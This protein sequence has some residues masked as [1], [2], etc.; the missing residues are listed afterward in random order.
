LAPSD[1]IDLRIRLGP[2]PV[3]RSKKEWIEGQRRDGLLDA[4]ARLRG[5][6]IS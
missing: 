3:V 6:F 4:V 1:N 5:D 2:I